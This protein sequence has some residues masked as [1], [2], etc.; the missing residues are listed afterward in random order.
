MSARARNVTLIAAAALLALAILLSLDI[1]R[2]DPLADLAK[3]INAY[4]YDFTAEDFYVLGGAQD[5]S[6]AALLGEQGA[7]LADAIAAS[8]AC[9]FPS[10]VNAAGDITALLANADEGVVTIY[11]RDGTIELCFLQGANGESLPLK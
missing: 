4:G 2:N 3:Q 11:L 9:G 10:D 1:A 6:I 8:K 5:T 7:D